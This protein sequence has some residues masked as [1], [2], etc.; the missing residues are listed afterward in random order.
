MKTHA[1]DDFITIA[2]E[3]IEKAARTG[4][5][6]DAYR[7]NDLASIALAELAVELGAAIDDLPALARER[8]GLRAPRNA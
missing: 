7:A 2:R 4:L 5:D 6:A 1:A 8:E 3:A